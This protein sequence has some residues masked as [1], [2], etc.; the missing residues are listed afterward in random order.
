MCSRGAIRDLTSE[1]RVHLP[2]LVNWNVEQR[3]VVTCNHNCC[4]YL[5]GQR[6]LNVGPGQ[7]QDSVNQLFSRS[8]Q[9]GSDCNGTEHFNKFHTVYLTLGVAILF[10]CD[11]DCFR[12]SSQVSLMS[13]T[14]QRR[15]FPDSQLKCQLQCQ[16]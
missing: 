5:T 3:T 14:Y 11:Y 2:F 1:S 7:A 13:L 15:L 9:I 16:H 10:E 4:T 8:G 12:Y 6:Y